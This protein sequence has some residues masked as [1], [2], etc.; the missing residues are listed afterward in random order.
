MLKD[1]KCFKCQ[2]D[3]HAKDKEFGGVFMLGLDRPY[4]NLWFHRSC[5]NSFD[6]D[7]TLFEYLNA[8]IDR[9]YKEIPNYT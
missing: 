7:S 9:L 1:K 2:K 8:E 4:V 6:N 5:I 3:L